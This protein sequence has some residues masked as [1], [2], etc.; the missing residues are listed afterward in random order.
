MLWVN[1]IDRIRLTL[2]AFKI[3]EKDTDSYLRIGVHVSTKIQCRQEKPIEEKE[4]VICIF[5]D[6]DDAFDSTPLPTMRLSK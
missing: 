3:I 5:L 2:F 6:I 1:R 4:I